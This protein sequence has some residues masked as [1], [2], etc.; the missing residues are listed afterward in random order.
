MTLDHFIRNGNE[1]TEI[2]VSQTVLDH[3]LDTIKLLCIEYLAVKFVSDL[4]VDKVSRH[5]NGQLI[6]RQC[7]KRKTDIVQII[8][9]STFTVFRFA[10]I[11]D[12]PFCLIKRSFKSTLEVHDLHGLVGI[13]FK[14]RCT[15]ECRK[16]CQL[17]VRLDLHFI[18]TV[19]DTADRFAAVKQFTD[20]ITVSDSQ[21]PCTTLCFR[22]FA[23]CSEELVNDL[24]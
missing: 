11:I 8:K 17:T 3:I 23:V 2:K 21:F 13:M 18:A 10:K 16:C 20:L 24:L 9:I 1:V 15:Q 5:L 6:V 12:K 19:I 14:H 22:R 7:G 4:E